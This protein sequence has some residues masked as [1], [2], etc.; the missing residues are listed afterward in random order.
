MLIKPFL[1]WSTFS[2]GSSSLTEH[3]TIM[4]FKAGRKS[5]ISFWTDA[6]IDDKRIISVEFNRG[7][8]VSRVKSYESRKYEEELKNMI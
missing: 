4:S 8:E 5:V 3:G 6:T 2:N 1:T 7:G